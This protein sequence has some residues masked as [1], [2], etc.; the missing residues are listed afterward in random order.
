VRFTDE[1]GSTVYFDIASVQAVGPSTGEGGGGGSSVDANS[2]FQTG[3]MMW[4]PVSGAKSGW[5]R[6]N[7]RTIGSSTSG[8]TERANSDTQ[9]LYEYMWNTFSDTLCPVTG[10]RGASAAADFAANKPIATLDMRGYGPTGLD[11]MGNTT[12]GR[13]TDGTPTTAASVGGSE[14]QTLV[15]ANIPAHVHGAGTLSY[16]KTNTPTGPNADGAGAAGPGSAQ[17]IVV[18]GHTHG[19]SFTATTPTGST[20]STGSDTAFNTMSPYRLGSWYFKI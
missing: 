11:D 14:K 18:S 15:E 7:A 9:A 16:Q 12:A 1:A 8:A 10:G 20:A 13:I 19:L 2:V 17:S 4:K 3:E 5:V 6:A